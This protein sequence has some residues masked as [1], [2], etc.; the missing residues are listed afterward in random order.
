MKN[1]LL[2]L[3]LAALLLG[4]AAADTTIRFDRGKFSKTLHGAAVR[5]PRERFKLGAA[6]G[7]TMTVFITSVEDNAVFQV[8]GK[9]GPLSKPE[10]T[11]WSG[12][13]PATGDYI[14]EVGG[15]RGNATFDLT[16]EIR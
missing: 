8:L 1:Q 5:G 9:S 14:I 11:E 15:T 3:A 4:S 7:Q 12:K 16:V 6:K 2:G 10:E 13:L